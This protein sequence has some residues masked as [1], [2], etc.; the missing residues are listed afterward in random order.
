MIDPRRDMEGR[1]D[2]HQEKDMIGFAAKFDQGA[3]PVGQ[4]FYER[5]A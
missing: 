2:T 1:T 4:N 3:T 5:R